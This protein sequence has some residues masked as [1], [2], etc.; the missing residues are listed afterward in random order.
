MH[1]WTHRQYVYGLR[2]LH[3]RNNHPSRSD[4]YLMRITQEVSRMLGGG[5]RDLNSYKL[6]F[7]DPTK[8]QAPVRY[9]PK[10]LWGVALGANRRT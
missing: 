1:K 7:V 8:D 9:D 4:Y 2:W 5:S 3:R 10:V 6:N